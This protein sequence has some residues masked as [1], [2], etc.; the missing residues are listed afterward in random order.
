VFILSKE[1]KDDKSICGAAS[2]HSTDS[3]CC[4]VDAIVEIDKRGQILLP[5]DVRAKAK[6][7]PGDKFVL[8]RCE[9]DG[10][11]CCISLIKTDYFMESAKKMIGP[12]M[13]EIFE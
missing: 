10:E 3:K 5:K 2:P 8:I 11:P 12:I 6:I 1:K 13:R 4:M 9:S 7:K